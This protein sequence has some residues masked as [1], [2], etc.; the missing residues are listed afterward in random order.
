MLITNDGMKTLGFQIQS[1]IC[2]N[3]IQLLLHLGLF[4]TQIY[5]QLKES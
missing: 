3:Y 5:Y 2:Q 1:P 4:L